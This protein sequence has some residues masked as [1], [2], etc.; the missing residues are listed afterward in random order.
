MDGFAGDVRTAPS[1]D[2][3]LTAF[4]P[5]PVSDPPFVASTGPSGADISRYEQRH[6]SNTILN[7]HGILNVAGVLF[8]VACRAEIS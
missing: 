7:Q 1:F 6:K 3:W 4:L 5:S 2:L 8:M